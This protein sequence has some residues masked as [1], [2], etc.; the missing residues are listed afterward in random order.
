[1]KK[2]I[3]SV[4][5]I[6]SSVWAW[7]QKPLTLS[8]KIND[9]LEP[10]L[11][12]ALASGAELNA[13]GQQFNV[14]VDS[15]GNFSIDLDVTEK[16]NWVIAVHAGR[17]IDFIAKEG[18]KLELR[19]QGD[20]FDRVFSF[21]GKGKEIASFFES[22]TQDRGGIAGYYRAGQDKAGV[23][24]EAYT[25]VADSLYQNE[26]QYLNSHKKELPADFVAY[27]EKHLEYGYYDALL[28]YPMMHEMVKKNTNRVS[29]VPA[30]NYAEAV[31]V[32]ARFD[33]NYVGMSFYQ[34]YA[35]NYYG[36]MLNAAG[37]SNTVQVNPMDGTEDRSK[38]FV[39]TDSTLSLIF[40]HMP[41]RTAELI[42]GRILLSGA[43]S[44][45]LPELE[46]RVDRYK[47]QMPKAKSIKALDHAVAEIKKFNPGEPALDF[48]FTTLEGKSM[49]L[50]DLKG[51]VVYMDFWASWCGPCKGEMPHAKK[52]KEQLAGKDVV[53]LYVSIDDKEDAWKKGIT[54]MDIEGIHTRTPG[55]QGEIATLYKI[56]SVPAY[57]LID[58]KGRF[59][60]KKTP[61]PSQL[62]DLKKEIDRLLEE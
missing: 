38:A 52:L 26:L 51:K 9:P 36:V 11:I 53:F 27:W 30:A 12:V 32:P 44:W 29:N 20:Q 41:P 16:F 5:I 19:A 21:S 14:P 42:A 37:L 55:W 13:N 54:A 62:A 23:E 50:S 46:T 18:S 48:N 7:A 40:R 28:N 60:L 15:Q 25:K 17:R 35:L 61:R 31:K 22:Y 2:I 34:S 47:Q 4:I 49:K 39:Q 57:F 6:G 56:Q 45:T 58:K 33:D 1:M 43:Q 59:A 24:P 10:K 8:G 3:V